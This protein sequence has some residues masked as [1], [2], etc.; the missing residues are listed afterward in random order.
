MSDTVALLLM[1]ALLLANAFFVG[2]EFSLITARRDRLEA[3]QAEGTSGA[4]T[5]LRASEHLSMMLAAAQLG[6]TIC[7]LALG[8][9]GEPAVAHQLEGV[10]EPLGV[11][12]VLIHPIAFVVALT[13]VTILHIVIGEMVPKNI[14]I[15]GPERTSLW[16]V[17]ALVAF[18]K[19][20]RPIIT[21]LNWC[22]NHVLRLF[23][24]TPVDEREAAYTPQEIAEM[25][26]ESRREGLLDAS[27]TRRLTQAL[28]S[29]EHTVA[30]V[31]IPLDRVTVL[32][33]NP[34]VGAVE[35]AV[36][37]TGFSRF[38]VQAGQAPDAH[39]RLDTNPFEAG[40]TPIS[41]AD[42]DSEHAPVVAL[43][44]YLHVKDV[45]DLGNG[46][47][48]GQSDDMAADRPVPV[49]RVRALPELAL[50]APVDEALAALRREGSHLARAV[51]D[52]GTT[53]GLVALEDLVE[54]YVGTVRDSTHVTRSRA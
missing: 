54:E 52:H 36:A 2:A 19:V 6:I 41:P 44:G 18:L 5:V 26:S 53:V 39:P 42:D 38:P 30:D 14:A 29:A 25:L 20:T 33:P 40:T 37:R 51:D 27:Q 31:T 17:P 15:A 34:T 23:G 49:E 3:L 8:S 9:L 16:L 13:I 1:L 45:L 24:V 43:D 21:V 4:A 46:D 35:E 48:D 22:A 12:S 50:S 47:G 11:P 32:P 7:S 10:L 28:T